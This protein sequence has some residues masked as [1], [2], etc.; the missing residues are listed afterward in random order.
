MRAKKKTK[1]N[2]ADAYK[3]IRKNPPK[4][5]KDIEKLAS[6]WVGSDAQKEHKKR[7]KRR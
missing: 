1:R 2:V 6:A 7:F 5:S 4:V 3:G